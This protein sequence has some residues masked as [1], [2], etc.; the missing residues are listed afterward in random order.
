MALRGACNHPGR[1]LVFPSAS[2]ISPELNEDG[3]LVI[4]RADVVPGPSTENDSF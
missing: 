4:P 3:N 1:S 2:A